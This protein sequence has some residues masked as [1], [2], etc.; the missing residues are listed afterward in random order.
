MAQ[1]NFDID[2]MEERAGVAAGQDYNGFSWQQMMET[3]QQ[4][5]DYGYP[6]D[7]VSRANLIRCRCDFRTV[8]LFVDNLTMFIV[9]LT[10]C[11]SDAYDF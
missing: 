9:S 2:A 4:W 8:T 3:G 6:E 1:P 5:R 10:V 11:G 7:Q